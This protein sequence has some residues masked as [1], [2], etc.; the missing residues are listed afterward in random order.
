VAARATTARP[1]PIQ[2]VSPGHSAADRTAVSSA[3]GR[4][5]VRGDGRPSRSAR[6]AG[7]RPSCGCMCRSNSHTARREFAPAR[8]RAARR[9]RGPR[10]PS[11]PAPVSNGTVG[12][13][14]DSTGTGRRLG[15]PPSRH[16]PPLRLVLSV[17]LD[18]NAHG[19]GEQH[20][21]ARTAQ[22][23]DPPLNRP[24]CLRG[25]Y[26]RH[27]HDLSRP[28]NAGIDQCRC[29]CS[30][31]TGGR[32]CVQ[33][34]NAHDIFRVDPRCIPVVGRVDATRRGVHDGP[35]RTRPAGRRPLGVP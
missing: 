20:S 9:A 7:S 32:P 5:S 27:S 28:V 1:T 34:G 19:T 33:C 30:M 3:T 12:R 16:G 22:M 23:M 11:W 8:C 10:C 2:V 29:N 24:R 13:H 35:R 25:T 4:G 15:R 31:R 6:N 17:W 21:Y 14:A 26:F 18:T